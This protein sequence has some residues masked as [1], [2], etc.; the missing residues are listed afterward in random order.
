MDEAIKLAVIAQ[1]LADL[2]RRVVAL[3]SQFGWIQALLFGN[4]I[5]IVVGFVL[6]NQRI[7]R[8]NVHDKKV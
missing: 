8:A 2:T 7:T 3:E 6:A 5:A 4:L 1:Q